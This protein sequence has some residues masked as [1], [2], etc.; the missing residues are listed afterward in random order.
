M[1]SVFRSLVC[2]MFTLQVVSCAS[3]VFT[4]TEHMQESMA[5]EGV[6]LE[7]GHFYVLLQERKLSA[8]RRH[9]Q[10]FRASKS[11]TSGPSAL[12]RFL[13]LGRA[14]DFSSYFSLKTQRGYVTS[15]PDAVFLPSSR[16]RW[17]T[18]VD[19]T[20][21]AAGICKL[22]HLY[23]I[24]VTKMTAMKS[25]LLPAVSPEDFS[26]VARGCY[27]TG[28]FG[29]T[30]AWSRAAIFQAMLSYTSTSFRRLQ[31][32]LGWLQANDQRWPRFQ[33]WAKSKF[34]TAGKVYPSSPELDVNEYKKVCVQRGFLRPSDSTL[35][36]KMSTNFGDP[37]LIL[38]PIKLEVLSLKPRA[39]IISDFL[40]TSEVNHIRSAA[41]KGFA[42]AGIYS[43]KN[44][45]GV[46][47]W[48][49]TGKVSWLWDVHSKVLQRLTRRIAVATGLS[50]E[51]AEA[52]QVA[53]YGIGGHYTP[54]MDAH[55]FRKVADRVDTVNGNRLATMLMY[56]S[57]VAAGGATAFV[58]LGIA[59]QPRVG[60]ALFWYDVEPYNGSEFPKQMSFWHQKRKADV[61]TTHV[62]CPVLWGSKWIVTKWIRERTNVVV[63][64]NT[65]G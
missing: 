12:G 10:A 19:V 18:D 47:S 17:P 51:S 57:N 37:H 32:G 7:D 2:A 44:T 5:T 8:A 52:Y 1:C 28:E 24:P 15:S 29:N 26:Y 56:L 3:D 50:M 31:L 20:G 9:Y 11:L 16:E 23:D 36:C 4:S 45:A 42:R 61:L 34:K 25:R 46:P 41:Q 60:D 49:R 35:V 13:F 63:H 62:G 58:N 64:Y 54:H 14:N 53:N 43:P 30:S 39:V 33:R 21:A 40:S 48:K 6:T 27:M 65:P 55:E 59:V 22:Q 38:Q